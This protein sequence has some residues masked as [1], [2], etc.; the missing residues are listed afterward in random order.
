MLR[1]LLQLYSMENRAAEA[2]KVLLEGALSLMHGIVAIAAILSQL[3]ASPGVQGVNAGLSF[4][5][6]RHF[7]PIELSSENQLL[8]ERLNE[9]LAVLR[10]LRDDGQFPF[11]A[12]SLESVHSTIVQFRDS[13][14]VT[15]LAEGQ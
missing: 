13:L 2:R 3:P 8:T 7:N 12:S 10:A 9:L 1:V 4:D 6:N 11:H 5:L 14:Q 15:G